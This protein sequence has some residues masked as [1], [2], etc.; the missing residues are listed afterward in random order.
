[1]AAQ[2]A[3]EAQPEPAAAESAPAAPE[4][5][6]LPDEQAFEQLTGPERG[7]NWKQARARIAE[8]N[9]KVSAFTAHQPVIE[10]INER[11]GWD[12]VQQYAD[13]GQLLFSQVED[14][15]TG[16][17]QLTAEPLIE[18][19]A[20]ESP[21]TLGEIV[22][23]GIHQPSP[24][25]DG[26]TIGHTFV[27]D[28]LGL[29]PNL[30]ET[31]RQIQSPA[32]AQKFMAPGQ[33]T[34]DEL[35]AIPD[36]FHDAYKSLTPQ[37]RKELTY[38]DEETLKAFLQDKADALQARKFIAEQNVAKEQAKQE[39]ARQFKAMVQQ[40]GQEIAQSV[41]DAVLSTAKQKL[42]AGA[43]FS[44]DAD[45]NESVH[46]EA[47]QWAVQQCLADPALAQDSE[48]SEK[49]YELSADAELR[50]DKIRA[51]Q[52]RLQADALAKKLE[53]RFLTN[54]TKRTAFWSKALGA[55][56]AAQQQ[57]VEQARPRTEIASNNQPRPNQQTPTVGRGNG[58]MPT[59]Q[60]MQ[61]YE[62]M[63]RAQQMRNG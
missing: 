31:Y 26:E 32:D 33:V 12:T 57:Q 30:L 7:N 6:E 2:P 20:S 63:L 38:A 24:W 17:I 54:L 60:R 37:Q 53:G 58:F 35:A 40:R 1:M 39:Q 49:L 42:Q 56:R 50:G 4:V 51:S 9:S 14:P 16:Q 5:A 8:L 23:K 21:N 3:I 59:P 52:Y 46:N 29:D 36:E 41:R 28:Y 62:E 25:V 43:T 18:R 48:R 15:N 47:I 27:R 22:W 55:S 61:Q 34:A 10:Q 19:L 45:V 13:L 44:A 11:G